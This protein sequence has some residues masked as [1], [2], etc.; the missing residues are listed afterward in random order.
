MLNNGTERVENQRSNKDHPNYS[1]VK[2]GQNTE[3]NSGDL[4]RLAVT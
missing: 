1:I 2:V 4:K 3:K